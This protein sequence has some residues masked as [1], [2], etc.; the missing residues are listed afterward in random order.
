MEILSHQEVGYLKD[1]VGPRTMSM[2]LYLYLV[3]GLLVDTGAAAYAKRYIPFFKGSH[4][5]QV[6]LTHNHEDHTGLAWWIAAHTDAR[7]WLHSSAVEDAMRDAEVPLYREFYWGLRRAFAAHPYGDT[8]ATRRHEFRVIHT[9]GHCPDHVVLHE[10][11]RGWLFSGDMFIATRQKIAF[12]DEDMTATIHSLE[13]MLSLDFDTLFCAHSGVHRNGREL[14]RQ[15]LSF[16]KELQ[17]SVATLR[18]QGLS[19]DAIT[20]RLFPRRKLISYISGGECSASHI[21]RTI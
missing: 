7:I 9:P 11:D 15:K 1:R 4:I 3:D 6:A 14:L 17:E 2:Q 5:E 20:R 10:P 8:V 12:K 19:D 18:V 16:L 13:R 21:V